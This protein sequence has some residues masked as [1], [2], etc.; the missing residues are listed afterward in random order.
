MTLDSAVFS[1]LKFSFL[2]TTLTIELRAE[3]KAWIT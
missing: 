2:D 3:R 1:W